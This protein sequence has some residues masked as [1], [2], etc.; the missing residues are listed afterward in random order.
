MYRVIKM[1]GD[2][3]PWWFLDG[4]EE[5][6]VKDRE[7][8]SY[9]DALVAY[10]KEWVSLS[11]IF[12]EKKSKTGMMTA[13]WNPE[14]QEWCEECDEHLQQYHSLLLLEV[15]ENMPK[16]LQVKREKSRTRPCRIKN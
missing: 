11:E 13:F 1:Y 4:W 15:N 12:P 16:G 8:A 7:Y 3:E 2:C 6:I 10:Q 14:E 5:D 9:R